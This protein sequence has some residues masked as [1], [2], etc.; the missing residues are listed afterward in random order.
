M[1]ATARHASKATKPPQ[2]AQKSSKPLDLAALSAKLGQPQKRIREWVKLGMPAKRA[3]RSF[4]FAAAAVRDWLVEHGIGTQNVELIARSRGEAARV[5]GISERLLTHWT[6]EPGFPGRPGSK[7]ATPDGYYPIEQIRAWIAGA[8]PESPLAVNPKY[9]GSHDKYIRIR[10]SRAEF[11]LDR[12]RGQYLPLQ[13]VQR[14]FS[15]TLTNVVSVLQDLPHRLAA[16]MPEDMGSAQRQIVRTIAETAINEC[17]T[18]IAELI[19]GDEDE[20]DSE[21]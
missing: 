18:A 9:T 4:E 11:E 16:A 10:T 14:F 12:L 19:E 15:R 13:E 8:H 7:A 5:L 2:Q 6:K 17:R 1:T 21:V 3:G 20:K